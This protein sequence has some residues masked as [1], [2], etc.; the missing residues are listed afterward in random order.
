[1]NSSFGQRR[2]NGVVNYSSTFTSAQAR[3][4]LYIKLSHLEALRHGTSESTVADCHREFH[5]KSLEG[6]GRILV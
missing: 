5:H 3:P 4:L 1:M 6:S 2:Q